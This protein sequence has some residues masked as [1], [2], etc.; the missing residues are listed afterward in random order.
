MNQIRMQFNGGP[1]NGITEPLQSNA[2]GTLQAFDAA[3]KPDPE[4]MYH[5]RGN[6]STLATANY[7]WTETP[8]H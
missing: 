7:R 6:D 5:F 3:G 1:K 4:G 8:K 2:P